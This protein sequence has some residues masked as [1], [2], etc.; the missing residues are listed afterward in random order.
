MRHQPPTPQVA[1]FLVAER[2][3]GSSSEWGAYVQALPASTGSPLFWSDVQL[4][5]LKGTQLLDNLLGY[6]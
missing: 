2:F 4:A 1:L 6:K 5:Q 3:G